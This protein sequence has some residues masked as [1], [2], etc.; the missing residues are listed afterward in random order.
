MT[1]NTRAALRTEIEFTREIFA[2]LLVTIPDDALKLPSKNPAWTNGEL[3]YLMSI[4]PR[5]IQS[6]LRKYFREHPSPKYISK[7]VTGPLIQKTSEV[8]ALERGQNSTRWTIAAEH[9]TTCELVLELL[10]TLSDDDF[11]KTLTVSD[12]H[13]LLSGE[14]TIEDLFHYVRNHFATYSKQI[15]RGSSV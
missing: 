7:D 6:I 2:R 1:M 10:D 11:G 3:L 8:I 12:M 4:G 5:L 9:D 15:N 13:P 14:V